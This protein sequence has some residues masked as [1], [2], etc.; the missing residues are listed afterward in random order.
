MG[1]VRVKANKNHGSWPFHGVLI[2]IRRH[3]QVE[4]YRSQQFCH[5]ITQTDVKEGCKGCPPQVRD[6]SATYRSH[7]IYYVTLELDLSA[8]LVMYLCTYIGS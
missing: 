5:V 6:R 2:L 1:L 7:V 4:L 8:V 3:I